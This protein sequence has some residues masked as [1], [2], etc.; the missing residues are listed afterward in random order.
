[1]RGLQDGESGRQ[2]HGGKLQ[3]LSASDPHGVSFHCSC[4]RITGHMIQA[5]AVPDLLRLRHANLPELH[6]LANT[7]PT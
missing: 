5:R 4:Q 7:T 1:M 6:A 2:R 3:K